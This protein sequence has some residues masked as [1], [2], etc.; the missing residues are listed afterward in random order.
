[1]RTTL[2]TACI[3]FTLA[4]CA[5][6]MTT[7]TIG[8]VPFKY[9]GVSCERAIRYQASNIQVQGI[10]VPIEVLGV[11]Q[12]IKVGNISVKQDSIREASDLIKTLDLMQY[13]TCQDLIQ[14]SSES[15]KMTL[16]DKRQQ[17]TLALS[18]LASRLNSAKTEEEYQKAISD[19]RTKTAGKT[20]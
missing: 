18:E 17:L 6:M 4:G 10:E 2:V 1:M 15:A 20:N 14:V 19:A 5:D 12:T 8:S 16:S 3:A 11:S 7:T 9:V 13:S